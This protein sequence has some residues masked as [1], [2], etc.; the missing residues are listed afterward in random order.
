[1]AVRVENDVNAATVGAC[2]LL[3][4]HGSVAYLNLGTGLAAGF[5]ID[6]Q[7]W[8]GATGAAGEIGH[9]P[10]DPRGTV[11]PCGQ[12]GCL[13]TVASGSAVARQWPTAHAHPASDM[14]A[15]AARGDKR[16]QAVKRLLAEGVGAAI[17]LLVLTVDV[18]TVIVG[19]GLSRLGAPLLDDV[20]AVLLEQALASPFVATLQLPSRIRLLSTQL[21]AAAVGAALIGSGDVTRVA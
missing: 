5:L 20:R 1:M 12:R 8:R 11:C 16:A 4:L 2:H 7:L 6:G 17:R 19:G 18:D 21:P 13:E 15:A 14:F 10:V 3:Q 9:I